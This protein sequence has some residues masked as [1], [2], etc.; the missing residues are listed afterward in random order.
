MKYELI[1]IDRKVFEVDIKQM[2]SCVTTI[3]DVKAEN[4]CLTKIWLR[5]HL[6]LRTVDALVC[7]QG[8]F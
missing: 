1:R 2:R 4:P 5:K 6:I 7:W 3:N 8:F